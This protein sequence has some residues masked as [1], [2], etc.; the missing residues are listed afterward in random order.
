MSILEKFVAFAEALPDERRAE[1]DEILAAIMDSDDPE[2][3]FTPDEL[4]ELDRRMA[5]PDPQ[6]ADPAEVEA[7]FR[8]FDRA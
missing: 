8:R 1:I 2:F 4:A 7:V 3:G 6:Y 5:D